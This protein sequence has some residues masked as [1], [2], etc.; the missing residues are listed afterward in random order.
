MKNLS[1]KQ[2]EEIKNIPSWTLTKFHGNQRK[3]GSLLVSDFK[4]IV[5]K[6]SARQIAKSE[7]GVKSNVQKVKELI[8]WSLECKGT[9]YFKTLIEGNT[10]IYYASPKFGHSDYNKTRVFDKTPE[11]LNLMRIFQN[12]VNK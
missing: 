4:A 10:G 3:V 12:I 9:P 5:A 1:Q 11:T 2:I 6:K 7:T 8:R